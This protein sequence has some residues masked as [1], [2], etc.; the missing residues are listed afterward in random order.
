MESTPKQT[1]TRK[2]RTAQ[3]LGSGNLETRAGYTTNAS[4]DPTMRIGE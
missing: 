3:M 4:P 1:N 2:K